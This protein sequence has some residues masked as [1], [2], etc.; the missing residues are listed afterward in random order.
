MSVATTEFAPL[1][2]GGEAGARELFNNIRTLAEHLRDTLE[3]AFAELESLTELVIRAHD[4]NAWRCVNHMSW[5]DC[6]KKE[7][8]AIRLLRLPREMRKEMHQALREAG[9]SVRHTAAVTGCSKN[10]V[11]EDFPSEKVSQTGTPKADGNTTDSAVPSEFISV[12]PDAGAEKPAENPTLVE[13][14]KWYVEH[15]NDGCPPASPQHGSVDL[16]GKVAEAARAVSGDLA[17][18]VSLAKLA[19]R[20]GKMPTEITEYLAPKV[21]A[22]MRTIDSLA[23][24]PTLDP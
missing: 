11:L 10:T 2:M 20:D 1:A 21:D 9:L 23:Q 12:V 16:M 3:A 17:N 8:G 7:F 6:C 5:E 24:T 4:D 22:W 18:L 19:R 15:V 14:P 13:R